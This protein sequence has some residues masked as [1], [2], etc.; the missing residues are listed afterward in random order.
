MHGAREKKTKKSK[1]E[2]IGDE[3]AP[4]A[5]RPER[6]KKGGKHKHYR[7]EDADDEFSGEA[8]EAGGARRGKFW[9]PPGTVNV[10]SLSE[11]VFMTW[12]ELL[13]A[14]ETLKCRLESIAVVHG[15]EGRS[16]R[17]SFLGG[18]DPSALLPSLKAE[19]RA[20]AP[21]NVPM[22]RVV[23]VPASSRRDQEQYSGSRFGF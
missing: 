22:H 20:L 11:A 21:S 17:R 9:L 15:W 1:K 6:V 4:P 18:I 12:E 19:I 8:E 2:P 7:D 5:A 16:S 14:R 23:L 10:S 13:R 3:L